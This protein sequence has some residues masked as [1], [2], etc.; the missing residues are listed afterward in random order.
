MLSGCTSLVYTSY[1]NVDK[2]GNDAL[3]DYDKY[4]NIYH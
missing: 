1:I 3:L 4:K 2:S